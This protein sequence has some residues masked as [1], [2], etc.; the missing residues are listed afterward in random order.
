MPE[1]TNTTPFLSSAS[2]HVRTRQSFHT[3]LL[4]LLV[5]VKSTGVCHSVLGRAPSFVPLASFTSAKQQATKDTL[6]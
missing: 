5:S 6:S 4:G 1:P 3:V 2:F